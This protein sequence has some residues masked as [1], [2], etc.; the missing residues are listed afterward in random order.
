[1]KELLNKKFA[2]WEEAKRR[3][4]EN[5][6]KLHSEIIQAIGEKKLRWYC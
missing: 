3:A 4:K 6:E 2:E 1:M 5:M